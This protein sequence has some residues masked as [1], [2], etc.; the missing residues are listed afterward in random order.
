MK[1]SSEEHMTSLLVV[2][3]WITGSCVSA[4]LL[5]YWL[6]RLMHSGL[7][8]WLSRNHMTHHL[9][10]YGPLQEQ[11]STSYHDAT[12]GEPIAFGNIGVEW[13]APAALLIA[14]A[15]ALLCLSSL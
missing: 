14:S 10:L 13:L 6:H 5:G 4:E 8:P 3:S 9:V 7:V 15:L 12:E 1:R 11:R 2:A